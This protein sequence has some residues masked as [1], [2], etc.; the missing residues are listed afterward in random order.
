MM[1]DGSGWLKSPDPYPKQWKKKRK[2]IMSNTNFQLVRYGNSDRFYIFNFTI[3]RML[4]K[5]KFIMVLIST[6][7][8]YVRPYSVH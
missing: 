6:S 1:V 3:V 4:R 8:A 7:H 5:K 2:N